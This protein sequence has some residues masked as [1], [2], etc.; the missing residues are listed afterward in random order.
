MAEA[1]HVIAA[2]LTARG[3]GAIQDRKKFTRQLL[4]QGR[5]MLLRRRISGESAV[6]KDL[7]STGLRLAEHRKLLGD[8]EQDLEAPRRA[9]LVET[10]EVLDGINL[11]QESYDRAWFDDAGGPA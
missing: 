4:E 5:E 9:F 6:S 3:N 8:G 11:L 2:T 1:Y 10:R 7:F